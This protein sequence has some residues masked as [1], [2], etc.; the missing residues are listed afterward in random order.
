ML[1]MIAPVAKAQA[2]SLQNSSSK[3]S[4][5]EAMSENFEA[6]RTAVNLALTTTSV[7]P[8]PQFTK[9]TTSR[10]GRSKRELHGG[11]GRCEHRAR[12]P[13]DR[14]RGGGRHVE[15][16]DE[17]LHRGLELQLFRRGI[18]RAGSD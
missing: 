3:G 17:Y 14:L 10:R 12:Q 16:G 15:R 18:L 2:V 5:A 11:G 7:G 8:L 4:L 9:G 1:G 6:V 13:G